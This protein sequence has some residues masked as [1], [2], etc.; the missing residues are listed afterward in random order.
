MGW[1]IT[2]SLATLPPVSLD[3]PLLFFPRPGVRLPKASGILSGL[4][5]LLGTASFPDADKAEIFLERHVAS[6]ALGPRRPTPLRKALAF[7]CRRELLDFCSLPIRTIRNETNPRNRS[8]TLFERLVY[9]F[10]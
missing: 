7:A 4:G 2:V 10:P 3:Q 9:L 5:A 8:L 1:V 6:G